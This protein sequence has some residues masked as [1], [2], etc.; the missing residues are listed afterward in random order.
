VASGPEETVKPAP[1][2]RNRDFT[3]LWSGQVISTVGTRVSS[4]AYPLLVLSLTGSP[5]KA[6]VVGFAQTLPFLVW[7]L[8]AGGLVDRWNRKRVMLLS[9]AVRGLALGSI[10]L[11]LASHWLTLT[12]LVVVA[13]VEGTFYVFFQLAEGA[14]LPHVV[15]KEQLP[16]ALAQN[17]AREQ[18]ADLAGQPLGGLLFGVS[19]LLPFFADAVSYAVSFVSLLFVR[20]AFQGDRAGARASLRTDVAE[21]VKWLW[22]QRFLRSLVGLVGVTNFSLNALT[23]VLIVRA[24]DLGA[25]PGLI[26]AMFAF[27]G[28][29]GILGSLV[30]PWVQRRVVAPLVVIGALWLWAAEVCV[31]MLIPSPIG[32]GVLV[33]VG[34]L[35][36]PSFNVVIGT[37][38]Y[39]IVPDR[40]MARVTSVGRLVAWGTIPLAS[41]SAG[42][43]AQG[44]GPKVTFLVLGGL[45]LAV[46][47]TATAAPSIRKAPP[48]HALLADVAGE[49]LVLPPPE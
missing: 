33:G 11:G 27:F 15:T 14:A 32:L 12:Q 25:S 47:V 37:Y 41:L 20:P 49:R 38:R 39:A 7:F 43:L 26:G 24:R 1:L 13:F 19:R 17:Q 36:G 18:G 34:S 22:R 29:G 28:A 48:L 9:D 40:L 5:A 10:A 23:L 45:L 6:G 8:P 4:L 16:T 3:I 31:L 2:W 21:G 46:A 30:A 35:V 42:V 44:L